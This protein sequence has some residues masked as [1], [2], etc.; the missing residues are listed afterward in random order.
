MKIAVSSTDGKT[1]DQHFGHA[2]RFLIYEWDGYNV[3]LK[4]ERDVEQFC[5]H[6]IPNNH[7]YDGNRMQKI[8]AVIEDCD[9]LIT[10][11]IG[12]VPKKELE[13]KGMHIELVY[14]PINDAILEMVNQKSTVKS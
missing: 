4:E 8:F 9:A 6:D 2:Q 7:L 10:E 14:A 5:R 3:T 1:V 12:P 13:K 11:M